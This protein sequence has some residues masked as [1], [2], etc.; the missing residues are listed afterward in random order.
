MNTILAN[1]RIGSSIAAL[2]VPSFDVITALQNHRKEVQLEALALTLS[3]MCRPLDID[4]HELVSRAAKQLQFA[5]ATKN[6][7]IEAI[8]AYAAGELN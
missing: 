2:K 7:H 6:P 4:P 3:A 1:I 5:D 8:A